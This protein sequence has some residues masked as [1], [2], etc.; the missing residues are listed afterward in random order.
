M[1]VDLYNNVLEVKFGFKTHGLVNAQLEQSGTVL[2]VLPIHAH[3]DNFGTKLLNH[4]NV[5]EEKLTLIIT[6]FLLKLPVLMVE[7]GIIIFMLAHVLQ[8]LSLHMKAV[9]PCQCVH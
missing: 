9:N 5:Q 1:D 8:A 3:M 4:A 2:F 7:Y 6:V